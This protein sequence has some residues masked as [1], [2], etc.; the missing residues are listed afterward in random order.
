MSRR[1]ALQWSVGTV[2]LRT[3]STRK[4][5]KMKKT[6]Y[7][8]LILL[9]FG[10]SNSTIDYLDSNT[11][12]LILNLVSERTI[13]PT[14][15]MDISTYD[16]VATGPNSMTFTETNIVD[17]SLIKNGLAV[18]AWSI[19][20]D[21]KNSSG[22]VIASA[23]DT[24]SIT[25]GT[26][27][28]VNLTVIPLDGKGTLDLDITWPESDV[29]TPVINSTLTSID[30]TVTDISFETISNT[31]TY[32]N[33]Q[34]DSGYYTLNIQ[35]LDDT[36]YIWGMIESVRIIKD[37]TS[38]FTKDITT[39][40][41]NSI[42]NDPN[43]GNLNLTVNENLMNPFDILFTGNIHMLTLGENMTVTIITTV[44]PDSYSWYL[45]GNLIEGEV[46]DSITIGQ[47]LVGASY[48]LDVVVKMDNVLSSNSILFYI[49]MYE[50]GD[51]GPSGGLIFYD[52]LADGID[53]LPNL[54]YLE[55]APTDIEGT[56]LWGTGNIEVPGAEGTT[57]GS[58]LQNTLDIVSGDS[59]ENKAADACYTFSIIN[60]GLTYDDW[61]L[62]SQDEL[63]L[64]Y[65]N[66]HI[67]SLGNFEQLK[68][69]SS[70]ETAW[71][72]ATQIDFATGILEDS[73]VKHYVNGQKVR[74]IR[75][76]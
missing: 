68:Y 8:V 3:N 63:S 36:K 53:N 11:G 5:D 31:A 64:M 70:T 42:E 74:P 14:I 23:T 7:L 66:L 35:L 62:P 71:M 28:E 21:A 51:I 1:H 72:T 48:R 19:T 22:I 52:D 4:K 6:V 73:A 12:S 32:T 54:R 29:L 46:S 33:N 38:I 44:Q 18:G 50:I 30:G 20:I 40:D 45:N 27:T 56:R 9:L 67:N 39:D 34:M 59:L 65:E 10:C 37:E 13:E 15:I 25:D 49:P 47:D 2:L 61:Y 43:F 24:F 60:E 57:I 55:V 76:F 17:G 26:T 16:I 69:W 58:G 75:A 41:L